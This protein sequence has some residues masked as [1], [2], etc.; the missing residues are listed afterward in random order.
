[1][2]KGTDNET[3]DGMNINYIENLHR[4]LKNESWSPKP[5]RRIYLEKLNGKRRPLSIS[6]PRDE[7]VQESMRTVLEI[8][9]E[10][11]FLDCSHGFRP[12]MVSNDSLKV[13]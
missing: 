3:L 7:I 4:N 9:L 1:M 11:K 5:T 8:V 10:P 2:T 12:E 6:S 13:I